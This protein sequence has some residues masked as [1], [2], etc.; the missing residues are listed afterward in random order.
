MLGQ[1]RLTYR[2]TDSSYHFF[3]IFGGGGKY[4]CGAD[5][6]SGLKCSATTSGDFPFL[7]LATPARLM[8]PGLIGL[9]GISGLRIATDGDVVVATFW[10]FGLLKWVLKG[11][12]LVPPNVL[13]ASVRG[14]IGFK[15]CGPG[16]SGTG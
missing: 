2:N 10:T 11:R 4:I 14:V 9:L 16:V 13:K 8:K 7:S 5:L 12:S 15:A 6:F 3:D 1:F